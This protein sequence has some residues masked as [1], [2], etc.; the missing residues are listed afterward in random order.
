MGKVILI[1]VV[2]KSELEKPIHKGKYINVYNSEKYVYSKSKENY[3]KGKYESENFR[4]AILGHVIEK[5][6]QENNCFPSE[7]YL[8]ATHQDPHH[9]TDTYYIGLICARL[10]EKQFGIDHRF[11]KVWGAVGNPSLYNETDKIM[12]DF[13]DETIEPELDKTN[14]IVYLNVTGGTPAMTGMLLL[15]G[16]SRYKN[17]KIIYVPKGSNEAVIINRDCLLQFFLKERVDELI[18]RGKY[19][20]ALEQIEE[21][22]L[23]YNSNV[24]KALRVLDGIVNFNFAVGLEVFNELNQINEDSLPPYLKKEIVKYREIFDILGGYPYSI[25]DLNSKD[26]LS[27]QGYFDIYH[28]WLKLL[29]YNMEI[30]W[31]NKEYYDFLS[32][33]FAFAEE[34]AKLIVEKYTGIWIH[35]KDWKDN[36]KKRCPDLY[37][38]LVEIDKKENKDRE[39]YVSFEEYKGH[40]QKKHLSGILSYLAKNNERLKQAYEIYNK[41]CKLNEKRN[42]TIVA[43]G[44]EPITKEVLLCSYYGKNNISDDGERLLKDLKTYIEFVRG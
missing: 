26:A 6:K 38:Y 31:N 37:D 17:A 4:L 12:R 42:K 44:W 3:E 35:G 20:L 32:R 10:L 13:F 40:I 19:R 33:L 29:Y 5:I 7:V 36:I 21:N 23:N 22:H 16:V 34:T 39:D 41:I 43:H 14:D 27:Y 18:M 1:S 24:L 25:R 30:K 11:I 8:I 2:G 9:P 28:N 15:H